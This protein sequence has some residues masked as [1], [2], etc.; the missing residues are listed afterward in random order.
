[1][2]DSHIAT[3]LSDLKNQI[4][5]IFDGHGGTFQKDLGAEVSNFVAKYFVKELEK[6]SNYKKKN[7]ELSLK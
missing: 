7:Y 4:F 2:E 6:N 5:G 3:N 1:M